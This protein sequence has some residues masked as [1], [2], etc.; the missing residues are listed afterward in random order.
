MDSL[1]RG[2]GLGR[3]PS[4]A[5]LVRG[6]PFSMR[7]DGEAVDFDRWEHSAEPA[8]WF[9]PRTGLRV[10]V[11]AERLGHSDA[12]YYWLQVA[13]ESSQDSPLLERVLPL[14]VMVAMPSGPLVLHHANGS[15][16]SVSDFL[17]LV[18]PLEPDRE[19]A[20]E[21]VGGRSSNG[22]LPFFNVAG[23]S[24]GL[25]V[26]VG[27]TG[28]WRA[29]FRRTSE[30]LVLTAGMAQMHLRL[31]PGET[32]RT[33][34]VLLIPW[35]GEDWLDGQNA[36]RRVMLEHFTPHRDGGPI[37]PPVAHGT[38]GG[39][40][41]YEGGWAAGNE[42]TMLRSIPPAAELGI[43]AY[44][45]DAY[46]FPGNFPYG[47]GN[48]FPRPKDF[49]NGLKPLADAAH[50]R[51]MDFI[52][53]FEPERVGRDTQIDREHPEWLIDLGRECKLFDLGNEDARRYITDV[54]SGRIDEYDVDIYR[55]DFNDDPLPFWRVKDEPERQGMAEIRHIEGL[56]AFWDE[57]RARHPR[58]WID[59]CASGG[60]RIDV[61]TCRR[62]LHLWRSDSPDPVV[63]DQSLREGIALTDQVQTAGLSL[64]APLHS[65]GVWDADPYHFRSAG[66]AG[67]VIYDDVRH[68]SFPREPARAAIEELKS[69]RPFFLGDFYL[70][71][72][73]T[74][75]EEDW[76]AYQYHRDDLE[77][78]FAVF[79]RRVESP[80]AARTT[81]LRRIDPRAAYTV[82]W[83]ED[84]ALSRSEVVPGNVLIELPVW[85][86]H[87]G[88]SVL[89]KYRRK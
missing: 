60:R 67:I 11:V 23:E 18:T 65:G 15:V 70:L 12:I 20:F 4:E 47:V 53:W 80:Y 25:I 38:T 61:E 59:N 76:C 5:T 39:L 36:L 78:G 27:W 72:A 88:R 40:H 86:E 49:P 84:Y 34:G 41:L 57:L 21:P 2:W 69:L 6:R 9:D 32:I 44:W 51:E 28:Q 29:T 8:G 66:Q 50:A 14:D 22:V 37:L 75:S 74:I 79:F 13:N 35:Q 7:L 82:E 52:L 56:Y 71:A 24:G 64:W 54:V 87:P 73:V 42:R 33:P 58:L 81:S 62:A 63:F 19:L 17:P 31:R 1:L 68:E 85:I 55:Q 16:N 26:A 48:W 43:E 89:V 30:G 46:W 3:N 83:Y 10:T 77:A 45:L